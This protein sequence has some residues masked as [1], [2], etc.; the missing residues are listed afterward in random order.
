MKSKNKGKRLRTGN[1][2]AVGGRGG[3]V[4]LYRR[5]TELNIE[6]SQLYL[7]VFIVGSYVI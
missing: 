4:L 1:R 3:S 6:R 2:E 7:Y 5:L